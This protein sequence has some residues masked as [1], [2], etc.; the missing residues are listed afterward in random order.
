MIK[1]FGYRFGVEV[2]PESVK[3]LESFRKAVCLVGMIIS[4]IAMF[5]Y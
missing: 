3:D 4:L 2:S 5:I 1:R